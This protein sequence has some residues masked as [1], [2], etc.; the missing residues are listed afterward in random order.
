MSDQH[1]VE[2]STQD[3]ITYKHKRQTSKPSGG[4]K[5]AIPAT[6]L[7]KNYASDRAATGIGNSFITNGKHP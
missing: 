1:I 6:K 4:F 2:V 3:N 7:L 5:P